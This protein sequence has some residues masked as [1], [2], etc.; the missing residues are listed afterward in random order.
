MSQRK[1][2]S[3]IPGYKLKNSFRIV[4]MIVFSMASL[5][6]FNVKAEASSFSIIAEQFKLPAV[7]G[8]IAKTP[9]LEKLR[10][11]FFSEPISAAKAKVSSPFGLRFHPAQSK[12]KHHDGIDY[13]APKGTPIRAAADGTVAFVGRKNGYGKVVIIEHSAGF[14]TLYAHQSRFARNLKKGSVV[15]QGETVGY[16]GATGTATG[17]HLHYEVWLNNEPIDPSS[18]NQ[19]YAGNDPIYGTDVQRQ[20]LLTQAEFPPIERVLVGKD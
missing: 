13:S 2:S 16:V 3:F 1:I 10:E 14:S 11:A 18:A 9:R 17:N 6:V 12:Q 19:L 20:L 4:G 15:P 8:T 5:A 7:S